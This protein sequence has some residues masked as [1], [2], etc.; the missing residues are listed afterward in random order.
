[1]QR[2]K[3]LLDIPAEEYFDSAKR[4]EYL[5]SHRLAVFRHDPLEYQQLCSG[6]IVEKDTPTFLIG[7]ATHSFILEGQEKFEKEFIVA[8]GPINEKT[9]AP[10]GKFTKA[11]AEWLAGQK[12]PVI[13]TEEFNLIKSMHSAVWSNPEASGLLK[14]GIAEGTARVTILNEPCQSRF[15]WFNP[16]T[17]ELVDLKTCEDLD[18]LIGRWGHI[19]KFGYDFQLAFYSWVLSAAGYDKPVHPY[20]IAVEKK[21]PYRTAVV[22]FCDMT[23]DD[24]NH[25]HMA[26][27][28]LRDDTE[29][30]I[31]E[32]HECRKSNVWPTR[33]EKIIHV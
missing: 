32:L 5:T 12:K 31:N 27:E 9:G 6:Q 23:I 29:A 1:M 3:F 17:G 25:G 4:N 16:D 19:R 11:Y 22:H 20:I 8:D 18:S 21:Q 33:F 7:R 10:F 26:T 15:D 13:S 30:M 2:P 28:T 14:D 24:L